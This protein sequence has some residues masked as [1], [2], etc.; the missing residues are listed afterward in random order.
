MP[1]SYLLNL[2]STVANGAKARSDYT[3]LRDRDQML[4]GWITVTLSKDVPG[5]VVGLDTSVSVWGALENAFVQ[6]SHERKFQLTQ[7][8]TASIGWIDYNDSRHCLA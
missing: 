6:D 2:E 1:A 7:E 5:I 4:Q 8:M 3:D